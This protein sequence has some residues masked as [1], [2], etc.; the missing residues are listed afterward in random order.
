MIGYRTRRP[1]IL[2]APH[3]D[4]KVIERHVGELRDLEIDCAA[5]AG[6]IGNWYKLAVWL[7]LCAKQLAK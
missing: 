1:A 3:P 7:E 5:A 2:G 6:E 4:A